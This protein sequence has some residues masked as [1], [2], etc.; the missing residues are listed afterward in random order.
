MERPRDNFIILETLSSGNQREEFNKSKVF[1]LLNTEN[2]SILQL[3][4]NTSCDVRI[5]E[6]ISVSR[7]HSQIKKIRVDSSLSTGE[8]GPRIEYWIVD[9]DSTF[10]TLVQMQY[11]TFVSTE[12]L[13]SGSQLLL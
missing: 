11:P 3:G 7:E 6:D 10:G 2:R 1:F 8:K 13:A 5:A 12:S 9:N 4:R